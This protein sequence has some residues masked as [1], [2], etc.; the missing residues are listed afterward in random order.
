MA[1]DNSGSVQPASNYIYPETHWTYGLGRNKW[2]WKAMQT[3]LGP[4]FRRRLQFTCGR[5]RVRSKRFVVVANHATDY[6]PVMLGMMF[7]QYLRFVTT[8]RVL[9]KKVFG[10]ILSWLFNPI[11]RKRAVIDKVEAGYIKSNLHNGINVAMFPEGGRTMNGRT[12]A[13]PPQIGQLLKETEG[14]LVT[15]RLTRGYL[16]TPL[17]SKER[18]FG[19][20]AGRVIHEYTRDE[21]DEMTARQINEAIAADLA[22]DVWEDQD[23][24]RIAYKCKNPAE[25][26]ENALFV[27]PQCLRVGTMET[28]GA[29]VICSCGFSMSLDKYGFFSNH[30]ARFA[31]MLEWDLWQCNYLAQCSRD[32]KKLSGEPMCADRGVRL[33][34]ISGIKAR[35]QVDGA[36]MTLYPDRIQFTAGQPLYSFRIDEIE[37]LVTYKSRSLLFTYRGRRY[38]ISKSENW[39]VGRYAYMWSLL[40]DKPYM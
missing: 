30:D 1:N 33:T 23:T 16:I 27:C 31:N 9:N 4:I 22:Y 10:P 28:K 40:T 11:G 34:D 35:P 2:I 26:M 29:D 17:W 6:D 21:L 39:P 15:V 12:G 19:P 13:I 3:V 24:R 25:G 7:P 20:T 5:F 37:D 36:L 38:E 32:W 8:E 14:G 18:R